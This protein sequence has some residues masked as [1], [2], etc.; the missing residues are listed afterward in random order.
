MKKL[1][2]PK[3]L[4]DQ[5]N[6]WDLESADGYY[7]P[8]VENFGNYFTDF[9]NWDLTI[10]DLLCGGFNDRLQECYQE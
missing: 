5:E 3:L 4:M 10:G 7:D 8:M 1:E 6:D 9:F 2:L